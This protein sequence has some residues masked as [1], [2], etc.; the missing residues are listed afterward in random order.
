MSTAVP[1]PA[2]DISFRRRMLADAEVVTK[3]VSVTVRK[4]KVTA[5]RSELSADVIPV[6]SGAVEGVLVWRLRTFGATKRRAK[7]IRFDADDFQSIGPSL[8]FRT[9]K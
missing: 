3:R 7:K 5:S 2:L 9:F 8:H 6:W 4:G 1:D